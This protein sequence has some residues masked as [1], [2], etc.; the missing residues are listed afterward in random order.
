MFQNPTGTR[1]R[2]ATRDTTVGVHLVDLP[3]AALLREL[4]SVPIRPCACNVL[5]ATIVLDEEMIAPNHRADCHSHPK[6]LA[7]PTPSAIVSTI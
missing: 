1:R 4:D 3:T 7:G 6:A 5:S 2:R